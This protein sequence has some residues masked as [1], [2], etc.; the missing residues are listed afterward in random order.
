MDRRG[1]KGRER[2]DLKVGHGGHVKKPGRLPASRHAAALAPDGNMLDFG[3][4]N[5]RV[6]STHTK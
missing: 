3:P 6:F 1:A 2:P 5:L 4:R